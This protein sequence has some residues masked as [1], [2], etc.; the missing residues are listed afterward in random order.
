[1]GL[2]KDIYS[3][4]TYKELLFKMADK[5][6][7]T[8][9]TKKDDRGLFWAGMDNMEALEQKVDFK[10]VLWW[11]SVKQRKS[12]DAGDEKENNPN[13]FQDSVLSCLSDLQR[14]A[15]T[16]KEKA[17]LMEDEIRKLRTSIHGEDIDAQEI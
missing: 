1:M 6:M 12:K 4:M 11:E 2:N 17:N 7:L 13:E 8:L 16:M 3:K 5:G 10:K 14:L 15:V 9:S